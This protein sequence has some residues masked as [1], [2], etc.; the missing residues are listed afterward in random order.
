MSPRGVERKPS[1]TAVGTAFL[2]ALAHR[3]FPGT[4]LGPDHLA[5]R[6]LPRHLSLAVRFTPKGWLSRIRKRVPTGMYEFLMARTAFF[7]GLFLEALE[8]GAPR[9]VILGA[10]YDTRACR[11]AHRNRGTRV[12]ELDISTTQA[13]KRRI[14]ESAGIAVP[15]EVAFASMDFNRESIPPVLERAGCDPGEKTLF[16]WEGV[17]YYLEP[18]AVD[19]TLDVVRHN[20]H[21]ETVLAFDYA[22]RVPRER[23]GQVHGAV[24]VIRSMQTRHPGER[25][26]FTLEEGRT[27]AFLSQRGLSMTG[28]WDD[29]EMAASFLSNENGPLTA[30]VTGFLRLVTASPAQGA[31]EKPGRRPEPQGM[32]NAP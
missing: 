24:D 7:D 32:R 12:I 5:R 20:A 28:H 26:R 8:S 13:R 21:K 29:R 30:P 1:G 15:R 11:F 4:R 22:A 31:P 2:R 25:A 18:A 17:S 23:L 19:A 14:L 9:I 6:F 16:L 10:G 27:G 3:E